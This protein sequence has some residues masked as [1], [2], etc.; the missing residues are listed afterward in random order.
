MERTVIF[1][2]CYRYAALGLL[3]LFALVA[4]CADNATGPNATT[5]NPPGT[6]GTVEVSDPVTS[7]EANAVR[8]NVQ[9]NSQDTIVISIDQIIQ[10]LI[11]QS[12]GNSEILGVNLDYDADQLNYECAVRSGGKVY[13]IVIDPKTGTVKSKQEITNYYYPSIIVIRNITIKTKEAKEKGKKIA[14][15]D[16]VECNLENVDSTPTYVIIILTKDNHYVTIYIDAQTGQQRTVKEDEKCKGE[17][18]GDGKHKNKNGRGHYRHGNGHGY[19]HGFHCH[20]DCDDNG[21]TDST[22]V[23]PGVISVDSA[24][25]ISGHIIDSAVVS[26]PVIHVTNDSTATYTVNL[27]RDSNKYEVTLDAFKGSLVQIKQTAGKFDSTDYTPSVKGDTLVKLSVARTAALAQVPGTIQSWSLEYDKTDAKWEY[28][29][30][31]KTAA[32]DTKHVVV[33]AKTGLFMKIK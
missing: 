12:G 13:L 28:T 32:G 16:V 30:D 8:A 9:R 11:S 2:L 19:G 17:D 24:K 21:N 5:N 14:D 3:S 29:F 4:G 15:G 25:S 23:P 26:T 7:Q 18:L 20:C 33:D 22:K 10:M 1:R 27:T 31:I 6:S